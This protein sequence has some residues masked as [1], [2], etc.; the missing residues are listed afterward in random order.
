MTKDRIA[1]NI[2]KTGCKIRT[3]DLF[4]RIKVRFLIHINKS[5]QNQLAKPT[6]KTNLQNQAMRITLRADRKTCSQEMRTEL[7]IAQRFDTPV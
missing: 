2:R 7:R 3:V 5:A 1:L 6:C 4:S